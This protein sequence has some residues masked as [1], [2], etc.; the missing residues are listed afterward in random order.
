MI[1]V[2]VKNNNVGLAIKQLNRKVGKTGLLKELRRRAYYEKPSAKR[3]ARKKVLKRII[4]NN[5]ENNK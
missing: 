4:N 5:K 2:K 3:H 1:E